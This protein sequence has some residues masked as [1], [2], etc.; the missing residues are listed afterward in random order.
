MWLGLRLHSSQK[1][2]INGILFAVYRQ[3]P[4][5]TL[6]E[7]TT[8]LYHKSL[9][10]RKFPRGKIVDALKE[11]KDHSAEPISQG[12]GT[13]CPSTMLVFYIPSCRKTFPEFCGELLCEKKKKCEKGGIRLASLGILILSCTPRPQVPCM[14]AQN[15]KY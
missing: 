15:I 1:Q 10:I 9:K 3:H 12:R 2:Y 5:S 8:S 11:A 7:N 4:C 14:K 13:F 6:C